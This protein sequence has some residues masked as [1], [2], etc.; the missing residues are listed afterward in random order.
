MEEKK[1]IYKTE[2][3]GGIST[4]FKSSRAEQI[5]ELSNK[6]GSEGW[7]LAGITYNPYNWRFFLIFK[8]PAN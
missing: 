8:K 6:M 1:W 7:E 2:I 5:N 4:K 3:V